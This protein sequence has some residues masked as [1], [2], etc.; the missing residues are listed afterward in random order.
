MNLESLSDTFF[1]A[2]M[3]SAVLA[4]L[5]F[6]GG[7]MLA[8]PGMFNALNRANRPT[9]SNYN[10]VSHH[11]GTQGNPKDIDNPTKA[12]YSIGKFLLI[13]TA[14]FFVLFLVVTFVL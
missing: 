4:G 8:S 12:S 14:V 1:M 7:G 3:M 9:S 11:Q 5:F 6:T 2:F 13:C 10:D